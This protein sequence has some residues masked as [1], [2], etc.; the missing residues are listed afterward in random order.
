MWP[1]RSGSVSP[2]RTQ[3]S[4]GEMTGRSKDTLPVSARARI[5]MQSLQ[6]PRPLLFKLCHVDFGCD[7]SLLSSCVWDPPSKEPQRPAVK[8]KFPTRSWHLRVLWIPLVVNLNKCFNRI[9][10]LYSLSYLILQCVY[11]YIKLVL[12]CFSSPVGSKRVY[13]PIYQNVW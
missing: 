8:T 13:F 9:V 4:R 3:G 10:Y 1:H 11:I 2:L 12:N 6:T 7:L 5:P